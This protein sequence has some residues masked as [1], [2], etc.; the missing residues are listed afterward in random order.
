MML[1][2]I[3]ETNKNKERPNTERVL[4]LSKDVSPVKRWTICTVIVVEGRN[5]FK[6]IKEAIPQ[7]KRTIIVSPKTLEITM[8]NVLIIS[9]NA[10]G[11]TNVFTISKRVNPI[12]IAAS[13]R[14]FGME[15]K[16]SSSRVET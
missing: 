4:R 15:E 12:A 7:V 2:I 9:G 10:I 5:G 8:I 1:S 3:V 16:A 14:V 13:F 11:K 6:V